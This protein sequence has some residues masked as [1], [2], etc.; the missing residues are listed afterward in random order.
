MEAFR[1]T[2][3][4]NITA[5]RT[6]AGLTQADLGE[7]LS[8]SDKSISKWERAD[9]VPDAYVLKQMADIFGV[10]VDYLLTYHESTEAPPIEPVH[11]YSR[12][13]IISITFFGMWAAALLAFIIVWMASGRILWQIFAAAL[14]VTLL[15]VMILN[16]LWGKKLGS[17]VLVSA[18]AWSLL[19]ALFLCLLPVGNMWPLLLLGIPTQILILL[20]FNVKKRQK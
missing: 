16:F 19:L 5:L 14:P 13:V 2:V 7:K 9:A 6:A 17:L 11:R 15:V 8:Y 10:T 20:S 3:A 4:S 18:F 1:R 12:Q